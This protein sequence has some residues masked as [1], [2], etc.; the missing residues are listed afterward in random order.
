[1]TVLQTNEK[2]KIFSIWYKT[3]NMFL[4]WVTVYA[5]SQD[6][7]EAEVVALPDFLSFHEIRLSYED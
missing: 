6:E 1:M 2:I 3:K 4:K 5:K 7:A